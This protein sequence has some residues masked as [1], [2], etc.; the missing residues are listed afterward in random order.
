MICADLRLAMVTEAKRLFALSLADIRK[1]R[2]LTQAA[3]AKATGIH[4]TQISQWENP[5][6]PIFVGS[7]SLDLLAKALGVEHAELLTGPSSKV[8]ESKSLPPPRISLYDALKI[9][10]QHSGD[11]VIKLRRLKKKAQ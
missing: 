10:N 8:F 5:D 6:S 7:E 2:G 9:V 1:K 11:L 3:L 4:P